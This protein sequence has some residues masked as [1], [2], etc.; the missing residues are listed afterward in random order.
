M[1]GIPDSWQELMDR[2][3]FT[4]LRSL[5]MACGGRP[6]AKAVGDIVLRGAR[7]SDES[8]ANLADALGVTIPDLYEIQTGQRGEPLR[9]PPGTEK[10][11][12]RAKRAVLEMIRVM[13]EIAEQRD[14][15][16]A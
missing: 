7:G 2:A 15:L 1:S 4:S 9:M 11:T 6:S 12:P 16:R 10:L 13:V 5:S 14:R 3:G 8:M